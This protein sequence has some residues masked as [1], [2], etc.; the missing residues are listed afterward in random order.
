MAVSTVVSSF[1]NQIQ[2]PSFDWCPPQYHHE[3]GHASREFLDPFKEHK[4]TYEIITVPAS[5][6]A[7][8]DL[9]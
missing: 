8:G 7:S 5:S 3:P 9:P 4:V 6:Q 1:T 2:D